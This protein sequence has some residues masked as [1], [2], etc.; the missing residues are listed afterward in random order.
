MTRTGRLL[1]LVAALALVAGACTG[2]D[3]ADQDGATPEG[4]PE[5]VTITVWDYYGSATPIEPAIPTFE[6]EYPWITV[7]YE[8]IGWDAAHEKFTVVVSGGNPPD[9]ATMDMTWVPT[10]GS[11]GLFAD[12]KEVSGGELNGEPIENQ[13]AEGA[14]EAMT[15][16]DQYVTM[17]FDFDAYA[18]Y[19]RADQFKKK[20]IEVPETWDELLA[21]ADQLAEDTDG[22]GEN[23]KYLYGIASADCFHW[24]QFLFQSGGSILNEDGTAAAFNDEAGVAAFE[25]YKRL[26]DSGNGIYWTPDLGDDFTPGIK[27]E[28]IGMFQD[29]PYYMGLLKDAAPEQE[30]KWRVAAAPQGEEPGS[31]LGGTGLS[32]PV[33]A[34]HPQEAWLFIQYMLRLEQQVGVFEYAGAAPATSTAIQTPE[35]TEP[36]PYFGGQAPFPIFL[37]TMATATHFPYVEQWDPI[38]VIIGEMVDAVMVGNK[39]PQ[40]ALDAAAAEVNQELAG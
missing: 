26:L 24:C 23:D 27:D 10:F 16:D 30:G 15:L 9:V 40:E 20:G 38:D 34:E 36:D 14:L 6:Q 37:D 2:G 12:L 35:L 22:D 32:I 17:L 11:N 4:S 28:T 5:P 21:A 7:K 29:G 39:P 18:L 25:M 1:G 3:E 13:Y 8:S 33:N 19:Y 31:Y